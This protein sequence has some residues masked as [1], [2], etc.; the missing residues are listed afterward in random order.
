MAAERSTKAQ[1][2]AYRFGVRRVEHAVQTGVSFQRSLHGPRHGLSMV[3]GVVLAGLVLAGFAVYGFIKPAPS[4]GNAKV[5]VDTDSGSAFVVRGGTAYPAMNLASAML[6][7]M[8]QTGSDGVRQVNTA[9]LA[10]VPRGQLLGIPGAPNQVPGE[11]HL[12]ADVWT[13]C[14]LTTTDPAAAP[15]H[16]PAPTTTV[17]IGR[18]PAAPVTATTLGMLVTADQQSFYL[19]WEGRRSKV[20]P[21]DRA[22]A[23]G[24]GIDPSAA[25][26]VSLGLLNAIPEA[27]PIIVPRIPSAGRATSVG[28]RS[29]AVGDVVR[30]E[31]A[32]TG[33]GYYLVLRDGIQE[34]S[35]VV[36]DIVRAATGQSAEIPLVPP[37]DITAAARTNEPVAVDAYPTR[38]PRLVGL[39]AAPGLCLQWRLV[40]GEPS[41]AV[42]PVTALPLP[43]GATPV[44]A[45]PQGA[46]GPA[47]ATGS[48]DAVYVAP[49]SG[50]VL[51]QSIDG[52]TA[53][54]GNLFLVTDQGI[55][56]PVVDMAAL[57][58]LG[59][60]ATVSPA[61]PELVSLLPLGPTLDPAPA[62]RFFG[63]AA[64]LSAG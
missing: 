54:T 45:P 14:D 20:D 44:S 43:A 3:V 10:T 64:G 30:V 18:P 39:A 17:I 9:T 23:E 35:G 61:P 31:R 48:A 42:Y 41:R 29:A 7:A 32:A 60:G 2:Q 28:S 15:G 57:R 21:A 27:A 46:G 49:G 13:V 36:A 53:N 56:Y 19:V 37:T 51:G 1:V 55:K 59:L 16:T 38:R 12:V 40:G 11:G 50:I 52:R 6:A 26:T 4:I 33:T 24:L 5:L 8:G 25:R 22:V 58:A 47:S 63:E 34:V 62:R